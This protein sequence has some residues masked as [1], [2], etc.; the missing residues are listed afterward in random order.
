LVVHSFL[1]E[2]HAHGAMLGAKLFDLSA[3]LCGKAP[4]MGSVL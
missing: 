4:I 1:V 2:M 3:L